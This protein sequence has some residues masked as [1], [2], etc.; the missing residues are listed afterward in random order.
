MGT[1]GVGG[2]GGREREI[3]VNG[4]KGGWVLGGGGREREIRVNGNKG[5]W[6][7]AEKGR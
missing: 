4:N 5:G 7:G 2:W 3:R 1:R 6:G